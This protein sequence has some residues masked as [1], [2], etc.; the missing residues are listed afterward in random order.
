MNDVAGNGVTEVDAVVIGS[1][2]A[3]LY[4]IHKLRNGLGLSVQGF[5]NAGGVGGTWYWNRYPGAR[6][7]TEVN[8]YCYSFDREL[9]HTW[10]WSERYPRQA[11]ILAYLNTVADRYDLRRSIRFNTQV[12]SAVFD[13]QANRWRITTGDG[14]RYSAEFL[15]EAVGLLSATNTPAFP[16]QDA[17]RGQIIH[18]ARWPHEGVELAGKRVGVIGTGSSGIQLISEIAPRV[19]HLT[20]FQRHAQWVVPS[21]HRPIAEGL[22]QRIEDD[23]EGYWHSVLYSTTAFGFPESSVAAESVS[24]RER[25]ETFERVYDNGG[26]FQYMFA[27]FNDVGTSLVANKAA[28]DVIT[29]KIRE[30]VTDPVLAEKLTPAELYAKRPLCCDNYYETYNR[31]NVT[32]VDVNEQPIAGFTPAGI[33]AGERE[34][35]FDVIVLATGFDAVS[36]NQLKIHHEGRGGLTLVEK[37]RDRPRTHLGLMAAGFPNL[38]MIYGPMGPFTNQP[39]AHEAQV[40]WV[41]GAI[42]HVRRTGHQVIEP[43]QAAEDAWM[44]EC[45]ELASLTLFPRVNSWINGSNVPGKP[46]TNMFYMGGMAAY[47]DKMEHEQQTGYA[48]NFAVSGAAVS[49]SR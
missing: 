8:A 9:F 34:Y 16:G 5:E 10:K 25:E 17:F 18:T 20:V 47:M 21:R 40:D 2:F 4:S 46:V 23:Y 45:D 44:A 43:T 37:W 11:E 26:G 28:T 41:A 30:I 15:I 14:A 49:G 7:D 42:E 3:G 22:L 38:F 6:S 33:R 48:E 13:E 12:Q 27:A 35:E 19:G 39:P 29:R 31:E 36:G 1:G 32:L 24:P